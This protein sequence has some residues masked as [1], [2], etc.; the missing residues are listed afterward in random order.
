MKT[1]P[2]TRAK[3]IRQDRARLDQVVGAYPNVVGT[4]IGLKRQAG[5]L[6][7]ELAYTVFVSQKVDKEDLAKA[8][9]LPESIMVGGKA[10]LTDV[11]QIGPLIRH[12][13]RFPPNLG[14][15]DGVQT[16]TISCFGR[17]AKGAFFVTCAHCIAGADRN[18]ATPAP[19]ALWSNTVNTY[20][21]V[22]Q[23]VL[24][25]SG[26]GSGAPGDFGFSDA[27]LVTCQDQELLQR[28]QTAPALRTLSLPKLGELVGGVSGA[29]R[30]N[31]RVQGVEKILQTTYTDVV[32][33]VS[34]PGVFV[35]DSGMLWVGTDGS[36][37][38]IHSL[39]PQVAPG[40][41][42]PTS[43]AMSAGRVARLL[44]VQLHAS[45]G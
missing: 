5:E 36:A 40:H 4:M 11:V 24:A 18:P 31:G 23:S 14:S 35:G 20:V 34:A 27:A 44:K 28:A 32:I 16:G 38:A 7:D 29:G 3:H 8:D 33:D 41:G 19:V 39:S 42:S 26:W 9:R 25:V 22:G 1:I 2:L 45:W 21:P 15:W 10:V 30:R 12:A 37:V 13:G 43:A 17:S 6:C